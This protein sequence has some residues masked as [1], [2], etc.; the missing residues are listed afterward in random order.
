MTEVR[1]VLLPDLGQGLVEACI[2]SLLVSEG[3]VVAQLD[4][5]VSVE[6]EK[7]VVEVTTPWAGTVTKVLVEEGQWVDV[8]DALLEVT[9]DD[10]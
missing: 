1:P 8:G 3:Q 7:A 4:D 5:V 9:V 2:S 6:T 10:A